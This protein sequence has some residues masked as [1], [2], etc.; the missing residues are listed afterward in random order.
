M[1]NVHSETYSLLIESYIKDLSEKQRLFHA[2]ETIPCIRDKASWALRWIKE[3]KSFAERLVAFA[4]VE[5]IFFSGSFCAIFWLKKRGKMPGLTF[6]NELIARDEGLHCE[7]ACLLYNTM[8]K[9][10][11]D[12]KT[13]HEIVTNAVKIEKEFVCKAIPVHLIGMNSKWMS[14]YIEFVADRLVVALGYEKIWNTKNPF[15]WMDM[16][17]LQGKSNM[18]ERRIGDYQKVR[19]EKKNP[20]LGWRYGINKENSCIRNISNYRRILI[21]TLFCNQL[22]VGFL[23]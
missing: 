8:L 13:V 9:N 2:I 22:M 17:S 5:G 3:T 16:I 21:L 10:K 20:V 23:L 1:E 12:E 15:E 19:S 18:F 11:L 4:C 14:L 6:S 7:F